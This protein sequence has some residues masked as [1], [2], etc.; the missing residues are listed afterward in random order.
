[1]LLLPELT[2]QIWG[3]DNPTIASVFPNILVR[4]GSTGVTVH[5]LATAAIVLLL[6]G[7]R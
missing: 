3:P 2:V 5:Q 1:M 6:C 7:G 4:I